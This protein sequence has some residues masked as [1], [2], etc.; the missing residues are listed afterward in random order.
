[1]TKDTQRR[2]ERKEAGSVLVIGMLIL[3]GLLALALLTVT[4]IRGGQKTTA[5]SRFSSVALFAA[6]SGI[7]AGMDFLRLNYVPVSF[8]SALVTPSNSA[9]LYP[10]TLAGN[11]VAPG[12]PGSVFSGQT[13]MSYE[14]SIRNNEND[15]GFALG[16]DVDGIVILHSVGRGPGTS[17][18]TVEVEIDGSLG[19]IVV[20][21]WRTL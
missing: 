8:F 2:D 5:Q 14:V 19:T 10:A 3:M 7:G 9:P 20:L 13:E 4:R 15:P 6:E 16:N 1:M 11:G 12:D 18:V 17:M 21:N